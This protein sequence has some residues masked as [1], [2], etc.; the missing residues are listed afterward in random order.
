M[1]RVSPLAPSGDLFRCVALL[2]AMKQSVL[3]ESTAA[4]VFVSVTVALP[5]NPPPGVE[6]HEVGAI[7]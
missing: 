4:A 7:D 3:F 6:L 1:Q 5:L 2:P